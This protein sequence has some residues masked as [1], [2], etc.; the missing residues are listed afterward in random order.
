MCTVTVS[1]VEGAEATS[2]FEYVVV[3]DPTAGY[4]TG[5]GWLQSPAGAYA[6]NLT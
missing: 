4:V 2:K 3:Y 6:R 1:D 5:L